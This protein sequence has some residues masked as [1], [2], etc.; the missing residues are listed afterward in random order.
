MNILPSYYANFLFYFACCSG[1]NSGVLMIIIFN[2]YVYTYNFV[3]NCIFSFKLTFCF[4][5]TM[6]I[7][8]VYLSPY[9]SN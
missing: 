8:L 9:D 6:L 1:A 4:F 2:I 5:V 3:L 7:S